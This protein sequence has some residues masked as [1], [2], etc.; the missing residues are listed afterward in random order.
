MLIDVAMKNN[1]ALMK[2][3]DCNTM[4]RVDE[5]AWLHSVDYKKVLM[6]KIIFQLTKMLSCMTYFFKKITK[7][8]IYIFIYT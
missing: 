6:Q 5:D 4:T 2:M 3:P 1:C 7:T 8:C